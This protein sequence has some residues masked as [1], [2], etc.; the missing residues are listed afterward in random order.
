MNRRQFLKNSTQAG[1]VLLGN[2]LLVAACGSNRPRDFRQRSTGV[3]QG[4]SMNGLSPDGYRILHYASLAPSGHNSQPW[5]VRIVNEHEWI[6]ESDPDRWLTVVDPENRETM[7]SI[8]AF[9]E[10][11]VLAAGCHGFHA[12]ISILAESP[13]DRAV[14]QVL[15]EKSPAVPYPLSRLETRRTVKSHHQSTLLKKSDVRVLAAQAGEVF[16]FPRNSPHAEIL[17]EQAVENAGIQMKSDRAQEEM[18]QWIRFGG[19]AEKKY[20]DGL[21][22]EGMEISGMA[23]WYIRRFLSPQ[24]ALKPG[25]RQ[26]GIEK[27]AAQAREGAGW[28]VITSS[29]KTVRDLIDAGRRFQRMALTAREMNI[30]IHPMTQTLEEKNG[31]AKMA[32]HHHSSI[33]PQFMLRVG[34]VSRYPDPVSPRRPVDWFIRTV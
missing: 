3:M 13:T 21:T 9:I 4:R 2:S 32:T 29:G 22:V 25:F 6:I 19:A 28:L 31:Q 17:V 24:D 27:T 15:L 14:A 10:N 11:L 5:V 1:A 20:R 33:I 12:H 23:A 8:G 30:A 18:A 7:L 26:K 16:Y 34:Y